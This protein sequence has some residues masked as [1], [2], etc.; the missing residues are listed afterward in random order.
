ME[1]EEGFSGSSE[2]K[3]IEEP[4]DV[5]PIAQPKLDPRTGQEKRQQA[6]QQE[7][8][9]K[10]SRCSQR[11]CSHTTPGERGQEEDEA[12]ET[13]QDDGTVSRTVGES[14]N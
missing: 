5:F 4:K 2:K 14:K 11:R 7:E 3:S 13:K 1:L 10:Q 6:G 12:D 9:N 8:S